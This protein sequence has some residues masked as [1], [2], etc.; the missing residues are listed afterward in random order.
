MNSVRTTC[1]ALGVVALAT[2]GALLFL[3]ATGALGS[4]W[5][6]R[7][8]TAIETV[9]APGLDLWI[10]AL[11][12]AGMAV[13][14]VASTAAMMMS[15]S[16]GALKMLEVHSDDDGRTT[17]RGRA[18]LAAVEHEVSG[19]DGVVDADARLVG[20]K[21]VLVEVRVDDHSDIEAV[22]AATRDRL[23]TPFWIDLGLADLAVDIMLTHHPR[24]PRVR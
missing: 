2:I 1:Q 24:P 13:A 21:R 12:G 20:R 19:I 17:L 7:T 14:G 23:D 16:K 18:A 9:A 6:N 3:E 5:R 22:E 10:L 15:P 11:A 4:S 8:A